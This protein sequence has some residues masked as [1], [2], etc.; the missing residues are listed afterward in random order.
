MRARCTLTTPPR[1]PSPPS[2]RIRPLSASA[3]LPPS[4]RAFAVNTQ[5]NEG[6]YWSHKFVIVPFEALGKFMSQW[7]GTQAAK[8]VRR[9]MNDLLYITPMRVAR[10]FVGE[11]QDYAQRPGAGWTKTCNRRDCPGT[12][13]LT[14]IEKALNDHKWGMAVMVHGVSVCFC[15]CIVCAAR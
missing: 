6:S 2:R 15:R 14:L 8:D 9:A 12:C 4:T 5:M 13:H 10:D 3:P 7:K 11:L 1:F